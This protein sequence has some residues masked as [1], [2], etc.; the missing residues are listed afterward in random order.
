MW[1]QAGV[2]LMSSNLDL[3]PGSEASYSAPKPPCVFSNLPS[4][5]WCKGS[6]AC[7]KLPHSACNSACLLSHRTYNA[8]AMRTGAGT[9][10]YIHAGES[11]W[12]YLGVG[13]VDWASLF[14]G[15]A[16]V[17]YAG[18]VTFESFSAAVVSET[19]SQA[20]CIWRDLCAPHA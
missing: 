3:T 2:S 17:D 5:C 4:D 9:C 7:M 16:A 13:T 10:R 8:S 11:H 1:V 19:H 18:P 6:L 15:L 20:L 12:G 14:R